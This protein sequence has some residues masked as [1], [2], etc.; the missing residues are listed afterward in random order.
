MAKR[1]TTADAFVTQQ[2]EE[3]SI[4][5]YQVPK[6]YK[7]KPLPRSQRLQI[8]VTEA[9]RDDLKALAQR[10]DCSVNQIINVALTEYLKENL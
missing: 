7:L 3:I 2:E 1:F 10:Q 8:L 5:N 6:G 9:M 4:D